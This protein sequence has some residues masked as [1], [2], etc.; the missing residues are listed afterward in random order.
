MKLAVLLKS[1]W[2][3]RGEVWCNPEDGGVEKSFCCPFFLLFLHLE[4]FMFLEFKKKENKEIIMCQEVVCA[5]Y[6][7][8]ILQ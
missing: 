8:N 1:P 5:Q 7:G 6:Q 3:D 4:C 2:S